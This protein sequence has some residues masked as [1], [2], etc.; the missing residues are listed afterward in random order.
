VR[1]T[2][3]PQEWTENRPSKG[4]RAPDLGELWAYRELGAFLALRDLKVRYKQAVFGAGWAVLQPLA[5]AAVF[6]VVFRRLANMPSDGLPYP[7]FA[8]V[9]VSVWTYFYCAVTKS[10]QSLV[11]YSDLVSK[12]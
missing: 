9:G 1:A 5:A 3:P 10:T 2:T 7:L 12:V 8:F 6:T 11:Q 4:F